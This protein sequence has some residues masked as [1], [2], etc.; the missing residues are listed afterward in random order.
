MQGLI[1]S[2]CFI[3]LVGLPGEA[4]DVG[5][6][7]GTGLSKRFLS[8]K[9][10]FSVP[11]PPKW[12]VAVRG[13]TPFYFNFAPV[14]ATGGGYLPLGGATINVVAQ[15]DLPSRQGRETLSEWADR[16]GD[17]GVAETFSE[18]VIELPSETGIG[19]AVWSSFDLKMYGPDD[20]AQHQ[21]NVYWEFH[22]RLFATHLV[23]VI[24][25]LQGDE[26]NDMLV[27]IMKGIR[28]IT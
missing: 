23:Y 27:R 18:R 25:N 24:G 5:R 11:V 17:A 7:V 13:N 28:T 8:V 12:F 3:L 6:V 16:D 21:V 20:Q 26:L 15:D 10:G 2:A 1:V 14:K 19:R 9:Y 22:K 4:A